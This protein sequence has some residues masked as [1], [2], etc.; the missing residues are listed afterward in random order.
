MSSSRPAPAGNDLVVYAAGGGMRGIFGAGALH[1]LAAMGARDHVSALYGISA[2]AFNIAQFATGSTTRAME[3]YLHYV[4]SHG[5]M[6]RS[7]PVALLR[8]ED[9]IDFPEAA[10][11]LETERLVDAEALTR[12]QIPV[13]FGVVEREGLGFR[14]LDARRPD[15]VRVL[16]ASS[17]IFPFV[18]EAVVVDGVPCIDGGY[19]E[20][21]C[22]TRLREAHPEARLLL[23]LNDTVDDS[24]VRRLA[25]GTMLRFLDER[26]AQIWLDT[27]G[28]MPAELGEALGA[29][30]TFVLKPDD[31]F[32]VH[33]T[34][35][36]P[37]V[38]A[39]GFW[40]G[41][42]AVLKQR[43]LLTRF[44]NE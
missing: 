32:P 29:P 1:A 34:T 40:L 20:G 12:C 5:I 10:L 19:R 41:Y 28:R 31:R 33:F 30:R 24:I 42:E 39:H 18:H 13:S 38:L 17:T 23:V 26:L 4:P 21:V 8:G 6:A 2:G 9:V 16:V 43:D 3:W 37:A 15:A 25:V 11:V 22:Y 14:W 35:T 27:F 36:D 7:T 44:L